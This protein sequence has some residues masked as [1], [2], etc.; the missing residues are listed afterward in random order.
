MDD[1]DVPSAAGPILS[2]DYVTSADFPGVQ[3]FANEQPNA[4]TPNLMLRTIWPHPGMSGNTA[5]FYLPLDE[6]FLRLPELYVSQPNLFSPT[7][8]ANMFTAPPYRKT[9]FPPQTIGT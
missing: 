3:V 7:P 5:G 6:G 2:G 9:T 8:W 4:D 1:F